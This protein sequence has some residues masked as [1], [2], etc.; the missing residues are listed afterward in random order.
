MAFK[1]ALYG[2]MGMG[3]IIVD[4]NVQIERLIVLSIQMLEKFEELLVAMPPVALADDRPFGNVERREERC[5]PV[6]AVIMRHGPASSA[7]DRKSR[8]RTVQGLNLAFLVDTQHD[9]FIRR[10]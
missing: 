8:L 7:F 1:P 9:G 3:R 2:R 5:C 10:I 4:D 6:T